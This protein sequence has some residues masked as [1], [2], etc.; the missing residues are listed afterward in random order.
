MMVFLAIVGA[1]V[2]VAIC[3]IVGIALAVWLLG[4]AAD[5]PVGR[6]LGW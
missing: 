4:R 5:D 2:C 3:V 1:T 6:G